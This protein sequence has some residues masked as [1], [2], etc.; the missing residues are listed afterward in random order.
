MRG[1]ST[2]PGNFCTLGCGR[3]CLSILSDVRSLLFL[4]WALCPGPSV[5]RAAGSQPAAATISCTC[6]ISDRASTLWQRVHYSWHGHREKA[7]ALLFSALT[8]L[9]SELCSC[10]CRIQRAVC[11]SR[12]LKIMSQVNAE[13]SVRRWNSCL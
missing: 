7:S 3:R 13:W 8:V 2:G 4:E 9:K 6:L 5:L 1:N 12:F 11:P 10:K